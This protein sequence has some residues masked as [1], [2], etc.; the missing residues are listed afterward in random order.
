MLVV[1][2]R[3]K[4]VVRLSA[5]KFIV[6][7]SLEGEKDEYVHLLV[8]CASGSEIFLDTRPTAQGYDVGH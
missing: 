4:P 7:E 3:E 6:R 1:I 5:L 2:F 8:S